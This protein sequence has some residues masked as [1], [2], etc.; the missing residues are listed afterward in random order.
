MEETTTIINYLYDNSDNPSDAEYKAAKLI[1]ELTDEN[2]LL[3]SNNQEMSAKVDLIN[4]TVVRLC[5]KE[6]SV[7]RCSS[8]LLDIISGLPHSNLTELK[9]QEAESSYCAGFLE[10]LD[11]YGHSLNQDDAMDALKQ[12]KEHGNKIRN[13]K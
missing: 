7:K 13:K 4:S 5:D 6:I 11:L 10:G 9:A 2:K 1:E 12:A 3:Q 8:E